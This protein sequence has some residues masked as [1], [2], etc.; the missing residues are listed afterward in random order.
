MDINRASCGAGNDGVAGLSLREKEQA[1]AV[2][3]EL[4][5]RTPAEGVAKTAPL[6]HAEGKEEGSSPAGDSAVHP[7]L[8]QKINGSSRY[9]ML[10]PLPLFNCYPWQCVLAQPRWRDLNCIY[11][12]CA[13]PAGRLPSTHG[14][15]IQ[16][17]AAV[18]SWRAFPRWRQQQLPP[19]TRSRAQKLRRSGQQSSSQ[20]W[21][22]FRQ[23]EWAATPSQ[24]LSSPSPPPSRPSPR[25]P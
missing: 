11:H 21:R 4:T 23:R 20:A 18:H 2:A 16:T 17:P 3:A 1:A 5:A 12:L 10:F 9:A 6:A 7:K 8:R 22:R 14:S 25:Q 19:R 24:T 15:S 13:A